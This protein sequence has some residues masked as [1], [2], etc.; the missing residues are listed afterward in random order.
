MS[1]PGGGEKRLFFFL[2][3]EMWVSHLKGKR[4]MWV[5]SQLVGSEDDIGLLHN[6]GQ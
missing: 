5:C 2:K 3:R 6:V 1:V 4:G